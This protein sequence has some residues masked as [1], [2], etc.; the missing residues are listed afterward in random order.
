MFNVGDMLVVLLVIKFMF[1]NDCVDIFKL[2]KE[3][4]FFIYDF[5]YI[6]IVSCKFVIIYIDGDKGVLLYCGYFIEQFLE[7]FS[8]VEVVYLLINGECLDVVQLKVFIDEL[9]V[10]VNVDV[11]INMLI[12]SFVKDVY[13]MVILVVVIVQL[14]GIYYVLLD[15][16]DVVQCCQVVVCL[17]V[18][19]LMLFVLIYCY[20]KGLLVNMLDILLDYV[21]CFLKQIF[22]F[23][24]G[25]YDL[26]LD[27]VKVL[28]LLFI[29]YVDYEQNVLILIVCLVGLIGV[30]LYVLVVVGV[31]VLWGL[32]YG[33]VNEVVLKMLEEIGLVDNVESVVFKVKDKIFGFCLMGFGYC[34]YK[35]FDL[36]VK[37]IGEMIGKVFKQFG[38][39]D[40]LFDVVVKLE[41][42]VLQ[43]DYFVV[44]K[45]YLNVDF[46]SGIIYKVLQILI[47]MFIVMFV[48][49]CIFGWVVYW[50]EQQVDLEM[51]IGCL[52]Q[53][54]IGY[55]VCDYQ[56]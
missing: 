49:G 6:V 35:N 9:V 32:V 40:L 50:L 28:D 27:V 51:K 29:L 47:E 15:L 18:K 10:E 31:I 30:N 24:D 19:V 1:G 22:E 55:D 41:Q 17:I 53:V 13:L 39:Q 33:G 14:L 48:F 2:I 3:I 16:F 7:K 46:Y 5:G 11:L 44:C 37:V 45:L 36:C 23:V 56:G 8:Y 42:V 12:V 20:G 54:Y 43:D 26:N 38:V 4:G 21:S 34:V 52:C 25:Q